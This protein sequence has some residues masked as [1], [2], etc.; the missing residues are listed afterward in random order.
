MMYARPISSASMP[1]VT[2]TQRRWCLRSGGR[3]AGC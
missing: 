1:A 3:T 2:G